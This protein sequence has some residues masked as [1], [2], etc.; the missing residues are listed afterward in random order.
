MTAE[1][2]GNTSY[3]VSSQSNPKE[4]LDVVYS[5]NDSTLCITGEEPEPEEAM[6]GRCSV[7]S[8]KQH[9][10]SCHHCNKK[11]CADCKEAHL[12]VMRREIARICSNVSER[13]RFDV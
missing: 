12:D 13:R 11:I 7:C 4:H 5:V 1:T 3:K 2:I 6:M 8:E 10:I 9:L